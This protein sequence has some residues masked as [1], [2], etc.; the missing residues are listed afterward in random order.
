[1]NVLQY[2][3]FFSS[4]KLFSSFCQC[5]LFLNAEVSLRHQKDTLSN[6]QMQS[7]IHSWCIWSFRDI[8]V[9]SHLCGRVLRLSSGR[10]RGVCKTLLI[11]SLLL[12][13]QFSLFLRVLMSAKVPQLCSFFMLV[14]LFYFFAMC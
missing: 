9:F 11:S 3:F 12:F 6:A 4:N 10:Y 5:I 13:L 7:L 14:I 8:S 2:L 1:M